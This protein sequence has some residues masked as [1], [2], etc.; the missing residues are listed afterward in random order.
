MEYDA[1]RVLGSEDA[2]DRGGYD[3]G[4]E[5]RC[6]NNR[7]PLLIFIFSRLLTVNY[8]STNDVLVL[9]VRGKKNR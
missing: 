4:C 7:Y 2:R 6:F 9:L 5:E 3:C 1:S 8:Y